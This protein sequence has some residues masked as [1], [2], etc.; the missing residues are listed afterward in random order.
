M[1]L[2]GKAEPTWQL[3]RRFRD[4]QGLSQQAL[5][6]RLAVISGNSSITREHVSRWERGKRIPNPYWRVWLGRALE[7]PPEWLERAAMIARRV[8][9]IHDSTSH[10]YSLESLGLG[11]WGDHVG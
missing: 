1:Y 6:E 3:I 10:E 9:V 8:R 11:S 2:Q 7:I 4:R 5:A